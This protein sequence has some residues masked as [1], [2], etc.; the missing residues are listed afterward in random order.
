M[1]F[2]YKYVNVIGFVNLKC[3][4]VIPDLVIMRFKVPSASDSDRTC[5]A[6]NI[7]FKSQSVPQPV[8]YP[9]STQ[10][11]YYRGKVAGAWS[12]IPIPPIRLH[13]V[14]LS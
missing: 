4:N 3:S 10:G 1:Y 13:D 6:Q 2:D 5:R 7:I 12:C 14:V 8:S 9:I 11:S